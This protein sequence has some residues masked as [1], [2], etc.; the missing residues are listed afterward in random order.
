MLS[1]KFLLG[2]AVVLLT[3]SF[4]PPAFA[5]NFELDFLITGSTPAGSSPWLVAEI[6][7]IE[8]NRVSLTMSARNLTQDSGQFVSEWFFNVQSPNV[9]LENS[10]LSAVEEQ[11]L[12][13]FSFSPQGNAG[14]GQGV[15]SGFNIAFAFNTANN[16]NG[17]N[18]FDA[19]EIF[20]AELLGTG[21]TPE[22]FLFTNKNGSFLS[23]A[24]VQGIPGGL[25]GK[26]ADSVPEPATM[27]LL[28]IGLTGLAFFCR[29]KFLK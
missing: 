1:R 6:Q 28:G 13:S 17:S 12:K 20:S 4:A 18:R 26:I 14:D 19:G 21:L 29:K 27:L 23:A 10:S 24:H 5:L 7:Q 3:A 11:Q 22:S 2:T 16:Q 8:T 15:I 25:S 9:I